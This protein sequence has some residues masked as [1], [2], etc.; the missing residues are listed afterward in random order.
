MNVLL[1]VLAFIFVIG[2]FAYF[3]WMIAAAARRQARG[4]PHKQPSAVAWAVFVVFGIAALVT[5]IVNLNSH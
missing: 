4:Q 2:G 1:L 5:A 3:A